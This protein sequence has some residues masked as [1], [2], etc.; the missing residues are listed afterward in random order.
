[1]N[2]RH[3]IS[4]NDLSQQE[5]VAILDRAEEMKKGPLEPLLKGHI[6]ASCFFEPSTRTRLSFEAAMKRLGGEVIG[7]SDDTATSTT[8]GETLQDM[9]KIIGYYGD[10]IVIR[11]PKE[12]AA[13]EAAKATDVPIINAGDGANEHPTQTLQDLF[14]IRDCQKRLTD[15]RV[16]FVGD[17]KYGRAFHSLVRALGTFQNRLYFV[18]PPSLAIPEEVCQKLKQTGVPFSSHPTIEEVIGKVDILYMTRVQKERFASQDEYLKVRDHFILT[19]KMLAK[20]QPHMRVLHPL[21]RVNEIELG[22]DLTP[23]AHYFSQARNGLWVRQS[24]L[25]MLLGK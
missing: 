22:V 9:M 5:I 14:T 15:L 17:L 21:P 16:A 23:Y 20:V 25:A 11:H 24:L 19:P 10:I 12:G 7:F 18:A 13:A 2:R 4:I 3:L 8:K 6:L 1:M